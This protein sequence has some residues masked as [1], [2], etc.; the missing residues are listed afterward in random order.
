MYKSFQGEL[1]TL[2]SRVLEEGGV[3]QGD[4][5][6]MNAMGWKGFEREGR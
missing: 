5:R 1:K 2:W 3:K 4:A 6:E